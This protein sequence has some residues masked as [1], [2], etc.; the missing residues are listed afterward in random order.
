MERL[1]FNILDDGNFRPKPKIPEL[2]ASPPAIAS[3]ANTAARNVYKILKEQY[4]EA[5]DLRSRVLEV[6]TLFTDLVYTNERIVGENVTQTRGTGDYISRLDDTPEVMR[7]RLRAAIGTP[8]KDTYAKWLMIYKTAAAQT[9]VEKWITQEE[10]THLQLKKYARNL[11]DYERI[12]AFR[13]CFASSAAVCKACTDFDVRNPGVN[14]TYKELVT[15]IQLQ[16]PNIKPELKKHDLGYFGEAV[17]N[18]TAVAASTPCITDAS[19]LINITQ[20]QLDLL[21]EHAVSRA[22]LA[23]RPNDDSET[24]KSAYCHHHGYGGHSGAACTSIIPGASIGA[25]Y[26]TRPFED[27]RQYSHPNCQHN[28][29]CITVKDAKAAVNP[30]TFPRT[31]GNAIRYNGARGRDSKLR[32]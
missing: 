10:T 24:R 31:P 19:Q 6:H 3:D 21:I 7:T 14:Q 30:T 12:E 5:K 1:T 27:G 4:D 18:P 29:K 22:L 17:S 28:P 11:H 16:L 23:Q 26:D 25:R 8:D 20:Q 9:S 2:L 32:R 13:F 15:Y